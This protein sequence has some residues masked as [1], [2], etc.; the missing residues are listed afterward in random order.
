MRALDVRQR[1]DEFLDSTGW[2]AE[3]VEM[4]VWNRGQTRNVMSGQVHLLD[5]W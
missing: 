2:F 5:S 3:A 1:A 4:I